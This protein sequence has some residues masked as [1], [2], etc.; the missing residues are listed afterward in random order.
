MR[1]APRLSPDAAAIIRGVS[2]LLLDE[3]PAVLAD[4]HDAVFASIR[5]MFRS[6]PSLSAEVMASSRG[7]NLHWAASLLRDPGEPVA[8]N[9]STEV[10]GIAR[11]AFRLGV[12]HDLPAAYHAGKSALWRN[13]MRL[14]FTVSTAPAPLQEALDVAVGSLNRYIDDTL[15][16]LTELLESESAELTRGTHAQRFETVSLL[17][18]GAPMTT[19]RASERLGYRFDRRHT[20]V[21]LWMDP[22]EPD[23]RA[24]RRAAEAVGTATRARQV[25]S[26][27]A[28]SSSTWTWLANADRVEASALE[29]ATAQFQGVRIAV[30]P[31]DT[32]VDGF[33][34]SHLDAVEAQRLVQRLPTLRVATFADVQLVALATHDDVRAR[35]F[36]SRSLGR[37]ATADPELQSTLRTYIREQFNASRAARVLFTHR[38][39]VLNRIQRAEAML[40]A[41]LATNGLEIGVALEILHWMGP[42][43]GTSDGPRA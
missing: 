41:P 5:E 31:D 4:Q 43:P 38:N 26:V 23:P 7:H 6:E 25:L 2:E 39:T 40:P 9:L 34:R 1:R 35:D 13:W 27:I 19:E 37:L 42:P 16:A 21:V 14:A 33:R 22:R 32:G 29:A 12:A 36:V 15:A 24:L 3:P 28:S 20:A 30:G 10:V 11:D 18:E 8:V 17:L